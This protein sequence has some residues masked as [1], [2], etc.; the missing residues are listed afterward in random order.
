MKK[1]RARLLY[2]ALLRR[3]AGAAVAADFTDADQIV[4]HRCGEHPRGTE[5][6]GGKGRRELLRSFRDRHPRRDV[7]ND[8]R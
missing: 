4:P 6:H 7:Q 3:A 2:D 5:H 8:Q 1:I